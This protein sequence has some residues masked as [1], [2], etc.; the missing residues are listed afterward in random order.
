MMIEQRI[1]RVD[2]IGQQNR[3]SA[4]NMLT[5]NSV[6]IRVYQVIVEKLNSILDQLGIDK[7]DDMYWLQ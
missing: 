1:G 7:I 6:D 5:T 2:R 4:Y 3:V